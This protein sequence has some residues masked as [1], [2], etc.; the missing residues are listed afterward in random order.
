MAPQK[1]IPLTDLYMRFPKQRLSYSWLNYSQHY[2]AGHD[3]SELGC[4][5]AWG[6]RDYFIMP[7]DKKMK[8]IQEVV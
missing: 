7:T 2:L 6:N 1:E 8:S 4:I 5:G 3:Y